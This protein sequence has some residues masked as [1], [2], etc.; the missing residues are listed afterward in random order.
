MP[1]R[2]KMVLLTG[3]TGFLGKFVLEELLGQGFE[4]LAS[5]VSWRLV[6]ITLPIA[7]N[8]GLFVGGWLPTICHL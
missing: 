6:N 7:G 8:H 4:V 5:L 3:A 2:L 1:E